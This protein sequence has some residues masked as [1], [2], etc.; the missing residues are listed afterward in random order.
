MVDLD[1]AVGILEVHVHV[2]SAACLSSDRVVINILHA[3]VRVSRQRFFRKKFTLEI[4]G[5]SLSVL[6]KRPP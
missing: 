4:S 2:V 6:K 5:C 1:R 3:A